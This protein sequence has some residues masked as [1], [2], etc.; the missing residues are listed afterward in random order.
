MR[1]VCGLPLPGSLQLRVEAHSRKRLGDEMSIMVLAL[2]A[3]GWLVLCAL[4]VGVCVS[5]KE[6]DEPVREPVEASVG[7]SRGGTIAST[8]MASL[9]QR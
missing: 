2:V 3:G 4:M 6:G 1:A 8:G 7:V 5:A 9:A